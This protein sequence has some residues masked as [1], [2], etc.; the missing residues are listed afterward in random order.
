MLTNAQKFTKQG[1]VR[2]HGRYDP[3]NLE[4][5]IGVSD[6][7]EGIPADKM[8]R[9]FQRFQQVDDNSDRRRLGTGLGLAICREF[10]EMHGGRIW[11]ESQLGEGTDFIF[12]LP[13]YPPL[14]PE[15]KNC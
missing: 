10:V 9:L 6:T 4:V 2:I 11:V 3:K 5:V 7:G 8:G 1:A 14:A 15:E 13:V 12:T